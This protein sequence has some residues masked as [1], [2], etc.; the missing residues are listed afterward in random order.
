MTSTM[1]PIVT[2][3]TDIT[4]RQVTALLRMFG[5]IDGVQEAITRASQSPWE[6]MPIGLRFDV[7][8]TQ[9]IT[10]MRY[11]VTVHALH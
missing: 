7:M 8:C 6:R 1:T 9:H 2:E 5:R 4:D 11:R 3:T 10:R